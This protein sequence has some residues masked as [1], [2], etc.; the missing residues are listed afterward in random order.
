[1]VIQ[2]MAAA[3]NPEPTADPEAGGDLTIA[4]LAER[5]GMTVR[6][7]REWRTLGL[8]PRARMR[9]RVGYYDERVVARIER[10]KKLHAEGFT[11]E[12]I[13]RMLDAG[14]AGDDVMRLAETLRAPF[15][16]DSVSASDSRIGAWVG[17]TDSAA[18][19]LERAIALG[20]LR[21]DPGGKVEFTSSRIA[22]I[23]DVLREFGLSPAQIL[24]ATER[25]RAHA[26]GIAEL[27]E[28]VWREHIWEPFIERGLPESE[29]GEIQ[30][31][32]MRVRPLA[33]DSV[34]A[35]FTI[36]MEARIERSIAVELDRVSRLDATD[37]ADS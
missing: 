1:M 19:D 24:E 23:G 34:I 29:L 27:F 20:V 25:I 35:I 32:A 21:R 9:G 14:D 18:A 28:G 17:G 11:L 31:A 4:A 2:T 15:R 7:L 8:L 30:E 36:A 26:D 37:R 3:R 6:N 16:G 10:V 12:L 13:S 22:E 5:V 33:L